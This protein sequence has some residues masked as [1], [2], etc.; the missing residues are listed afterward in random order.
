MCWKYKI[1]IFSNDIMYK[2]NGKIIKTEVVEDS[3]NG[4]TN[5]TI[6]RIK[7]PLFKNFSIDYSEIQNTYKF[8]HKDNY[9]HV[10][11][12]KS[13]S[14]FSGFYVAYIQSQWQLFW[15]GSCHS[16]SHE[17]WNSESKRK[18]ISFYNSIFNLYYVC[19]ISNRLTV[20]MGKHF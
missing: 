2:W 5:V 19:W 14:Y 8:T 11:K 20:Y 6:I 15:Q 12:L 4:S 3:S 13:I 10:S 17:K 18:Y 9:F 16:L 1:L 7:W